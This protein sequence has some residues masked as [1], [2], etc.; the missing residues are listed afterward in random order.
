M[1]VKNPRVARRYAHALMEVAADQQVVDEAGESLALVARTVAASRELRM[2]L[3][4]PLIAEGRKVS[5]MRALFERR[6][7]RLSM[8]FIILLIRKHREGYLEEVIAQFH[9]LRDELQNVVTVD[10]TAAVPLLPGQ[11]KALRAELERR[12]GKHVRLRLASDPAVMG[13]L[14]VRIGDTVLD[15]SVA[16]QLARLRTRLAGAA[17]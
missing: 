12:T 3:A 9:A 16:H 1:A 13:G 14:V 17:G 7:D 15:A 4:S 6:I 10:V 8:E 5:V 11:E 2:L